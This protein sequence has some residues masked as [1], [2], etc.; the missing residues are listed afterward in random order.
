MNRVVDA[1]TRRRLLR[2]GVQ[3]EYATLIWNVGEATVV[4]VA[5][6]LAHSVALTGFGLDSVLEIFAS[7]VVIWQLKGGRPKRERRALRMIGAAFFGIAAFV[8][9]ESTRTLLVRAHP[10][11]SVLG[12]I[13][14]AATAAEM[15]LLGVWKGRI[16]KQL[17]HRVLKTEARVTLTDGYLASSILLGLALNAAFAWWWADPLAALVIVVYGVKEGREAWRHH[18]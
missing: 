11:T 8:L 2:R 14:L 16:G 9:T 10:H 6:A 7:L 18:A 17:D 3:L 13:S 5:A 1:S 12:M 15:I 4:L